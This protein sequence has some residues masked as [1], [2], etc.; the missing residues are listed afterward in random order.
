M[1]TTKDLIDAVISMID[2]TNREA[3][4]LEGDILP[5]LNRGWR[6]ATDIMA[7]RNEDL[8]LTTAVFT[9]AELQ[10]DVEGNYFLAIP[11]DAY[12]QR[13]M[14]VEVRNSTFP[15]WY[16]AQ[17]I[18]AQESNKREDST[19]RQ[20]NIVV[21][22]VSYYQLSRKLVLNPKG[23]I[24]GLSGVRLRYVKRPLPLVLP[25][26]QITAIDRV[27]NNL[28]VDAIGDSLSYSTADVGNF[29][30]IINPLTGEVKSSHQILELNGGVQIRLRTTPTRTTHKGQTIVGALPATVAIDDYVCVTSGSCVPFIEE[31][32]TTLAIEQAAAEIKK[33][34]GEADQGSLAQAVKQQELK[35]EDMSNNRPQRYR[36]NCT[37]SWTKARR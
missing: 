3:V 32:A 31:P 8:L 17:L 19:V 10:L 25:Q 24:S 14:Q 23:V 33:K 1:L 20:R 34:L 26:G 2:H 30:N 18:N 35:V 6:N 4:T 9:P 36:R 27:N 28:T 13:V 12:Q 7:R 37:A 15:D 29:I 22:D 16:S 21:S 5:A 11:E